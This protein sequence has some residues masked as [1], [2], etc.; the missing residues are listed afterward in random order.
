MPPRTKAAAEP[1]QADVGPADYPDLTGVTVHQALTQ[2]QREIGPIAKSRRVQEGRGP[3]FNFRGI[4]DVLN[5]VHEPFA[6][7]GVR[8]VPS[9]WE[10]VE[11]SIGET[12]SGTTQLH[13]RGRHIFTV[14]GPNGDFIEMAAPAEALDLSD[15]AASKAMSMAYKY[16][17]IQML[18]IPVEAGA[19]DESDQTSEPYQQPAAPT[20]DMAQVRAKIE[21][22]ATALDM[23]VEEVTAKYRNERLGDVTVK[24]MWQLPPEQVFP[25]ARQLAA[26]VQTAPKRTR[27]KAAPKDTPDGVALVNDDTPDPD[28]TEVAEWSDESRPT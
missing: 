23:T 6:R 18:A 24:A 14:Y 27:K 1:E 16:V 10:Q 3:K 11:S 2:V 9:D 12:K 13:V 26:Y 22:C 5:A 19:L 4:D 7:W 25:L 20:L 21:E 17:V 28:G 8:V 15:K